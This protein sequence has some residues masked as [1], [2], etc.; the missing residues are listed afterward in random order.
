M[1]QFAPKQNE[2]ATP[3]LSVL[4]I[5]GRWN[6]KQLKMMHNSRPIS[7]RPAIENNQFS[8]RLNV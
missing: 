3:R 1:L 4:M 8:E 6:K 5:R 7:H 2:S